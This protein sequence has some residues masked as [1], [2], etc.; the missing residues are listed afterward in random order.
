MR[1]FILPFFILAIHFFPSTLGSQVAI[2]IVSGVRTTLRF[3]CQSG[4]DDLGTHE[5]QLSEEFSWQFKPQIFYRTLFFC[6]FYWE[7]KDRSF[8]V[9]DRKLAQQYCGGDDL[10][11]TYNCYWLATPSGFFISTDKTS[12]IKINDWTQP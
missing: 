11:A 9:Y 10:G 2:H 6:H 12:W 8:A 7:S 3:R 5:L 4:N 1:Q